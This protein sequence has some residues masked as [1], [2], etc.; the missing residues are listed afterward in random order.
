MWLRL[1]LKSLLTLIV[2]SACSSADTQRM[3]KLNVLSYSYHYRNI[4]SVEY[5]C[6]KQLHEGN[7]VGEHAY[8][9]GEAERLNNLAFVNIVRMEYKKAES[10]LKTIPEITDN[11]IELLI[12]Y[13]QQMRLCQRRSQNKD[14]YDYRERALNCMKRIAEE[15]GMLNEHQQHRMLYAETEFA[16]VCSTYYYYI[17]L[18]RQSIEALMAINPDEVKP[19]TAQFLNYLYNIGAG[20]ILNEGTAA[21]I[22][23]QEMDYLLRC[24]Q[25]AQRNGFPYFTANALEAIAEHLIDTPSCDELQ[26]VLVNPENVPLD[27]LPVVLA[28]EALHLFQQYG[29]VYQIAGAYRTLASCFRANGDNDSALY[30]LQQALSDSLILQAPDLVASIREQLSVVYSAIDD[31][32][33]SDYNRNLYLDLQEQT[34]QD[35]QLEARADQL[36]RAVSQL[37]WIMATVCASIVLLL[38]LLLFF[39][40]KNSSH[41]K[42]ENP[43][44]GQLDDL[45]EQLAES[46]LNIEEGERRHLEQ[47]AKISLVNSMLPLIDRMVYAVE[48]GG[49]REYISELTEKIESDNSLLTQWIQLRQG[50][51]SLRIESFPLQPLF[52]IVSRSRKSFLMKGI[53]LN[54]EPTDAVVKA[55][56]ILTLFMLNTLADNARKF[57]ADGGQVTIS[58]EEAPD[59]VEISVKDTGVGMDQEQLSNVFNHQLTTH[60]FGLL[61]CKGIIER[62]RKMSQLF[63][64]CAIKAESRKGQGSRFFFRLPKGKALIAVAALIALSLPA[65]T[66]TPQPIDITPHSPLD[67]AAVYADSAYF[68][69]INGT[70]ERTLLF[71][72]SCLHCLNDHYRQQRPKGT[73]FL[74]LEG[75]ASVTSPEVTWL[76]DSLSTNYNII[77]DA[78]NECAVAA[79]AMHKWSLYSYNNRIYTQLFKELSADSTLADY[80]RTMQQTRS[81]RMIAV[82]MLIL[83]L[84]AILPAYYFFYL[85]PRLNARFSAERQ[86]REQ[87]ELLRDEQRR[88][89]LELSNLHVSNSVLDNC[90]STLKHETMY[91]PSRIRQIV[92]QEDMESVGE[93]VN[94]YRELYTLLSQQAMS[95]VERVKLHLVRLPNG[96]LG[97][98]VLVRYLF[99]II[100]RETGRKNNEAEYK[101]YG[102]KYIEV[103]FSNVNRM[104]DIPR[105]LC[106]QI[107]RDHG[108][109]TNRRACSIRMESKPDGNENLIIILPA[110]GEV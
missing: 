2:F 82:A 48:H 40:R 16:I 66:S 103:T 77:L 90:L 35:R 106:R 73:L 10:L 44:D 28:E 37:N 56:R 5:Y 1:A 63:N 14:F 12:G 6:Q 76:H 17:G 62:Y 100:R 68:S 19:D 24:Y 42:T 27:E 85:R 3:D 93:V 13:V 47:R 29:D 84:L 80:C 65:L 33:A 52:D 53:T 64:V 86:Q 71:V 81:N 79:L 31:K 39:R 20:G 70:Y 78:R 30:N 95:Q 8:R 83:I 21:E 108:E 60:G 34:R 55:D 74:Q 22:Y 67:R 25:I 45:R 23:Q 92:A 88:A 11:Q 50:Q 110:Y 43:L 102:D 69:N 15:R 36:N 91:Y 57:T 58:S 49:D 94:Y 101:P 98:E 4:D 104:K 32:P 38:F 7:G 9:D 97:D 51:L 41:S 54:V 61:N 96:I 89:E 46:R 107:V 59:Y 18:E 75:D 109:A 99:D 26:L 72:D 105:M 87:L